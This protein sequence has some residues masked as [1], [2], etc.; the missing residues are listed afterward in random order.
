MTDRVSGVAKRFHRAYYN[1]GPSTWE[2]TRWF[3]Q[4]ML[5]NPMDLWTYQELIHRLS[6]DLIVETGTFEGGSAYYFAMLM[7]LIGHGE[8]VTIDIEPRPGRPEH[9]RITYLTGSST[10]SAILEIVAARCRDQQTVMVILDSDHTEAHVRTELE[11]YWRFVTPGSYL[12]VE[13]TNVNGHPVAPEYGPGPM[14]AVETFL[15]TSEEFDVDTT[16]ERHLLTFNPNGWLRRR[17][18]IDPA[19]DVG[20]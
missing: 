6:P 17:A 14:E 8:I 7:D 9:P 11:K 2:T 4:R 20:G 5:K 1:A 3:G 16:M 12:V 18:R 10:A 15:A 13:D 19:G